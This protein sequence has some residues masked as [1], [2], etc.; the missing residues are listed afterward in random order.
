MIKKKIKEI[1]ASAGIEECSVCEFS[2]V[3]QR[4]LDCRAKARLP[5]NAKSIIMAAFPYR[6]KKEKPKNISRYAAVKDYHI[7]CKEMLET[8]KGMLEAA[9]PNN[10]F[11]VFLDNSPIP[12]V[13]A[14]HHSGLGILGKNGLIINKK[15]GSYVFLG[16][17]VTNLRVVADKG[18]E[19][20]RDCGRCISACPINMRKEHCLSAVN[21]QKKLL[22]D[23]QVELI[24]QSGC[25]WG[26]DICSEVCPHNKD[27]QNTYID[28]FINSYR[29]EYLLGE[30]MNERA[31]MWRGK[32]VIERN[33]KIITDK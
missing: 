12:E 20:C 23:T 27:V 7:V 18:G 3:A 16:E 31:Y 29:N 8:A 24:K 19:K 15:Y 21:Q 13:A 2:F 9:F 22:N 17:I 5:E 11:E 28:E 25:V 4:L 30:D 32:E 1:L 14:A 33:N 6:V 10:C 26:C